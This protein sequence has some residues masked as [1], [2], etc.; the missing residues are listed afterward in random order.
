MPGVLAWDG[1][2]ALDDAFIEGLGPAD[3]IGCGLD[4]DRFKARH[5]AAFEYWRDVSVDPIVIAVSGAVLDD[6]H[7]R[8]PLLECAPH[9][10]KH[11]R[12]HVGVADDVLWCTNQ[13]GSVKTTD[14]DEGVIT[15][16]N[17]AAGVGRGDELLLRGQRNFALG[18]GLVV[19]HS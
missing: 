6:S 4:P 14:L 3:L 1:R 18:N 13:V 2:F 9:M 7:P 10:G 12:G 15:V 17:D 8:T 5:P 16:G 11:G 19:S